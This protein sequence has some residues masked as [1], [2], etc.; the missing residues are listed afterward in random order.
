MIVG[1]AGV[2][3]AVCCFPIGLVMGGVSLGLGLIARRE[4]EGSGGA[5]A[6]GGMA[7]AGIVLGALE[8]L[9]V[10]FVIVIIIASIASG[11]FH[12]VTPGPGIP[13]R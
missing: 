5:Q 13:S 1:I 10:L 8:L 3:F 12:G 9:W 11:N 4:I 7:I 2:L 6:G